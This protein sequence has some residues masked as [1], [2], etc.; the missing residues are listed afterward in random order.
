MFFSNHA[1]IQKWS[2]VC[3]L[4]YHMKITEPIVLIL[5]IYIVNISEYNRHTHFNFLLFFKMVS[6]I[7]TSLQSLLNGSTLFN[8]VYIYYIKQTVHLSKYLMTNSRKLIKLS[9]PIKCLFIYLSISSHC[10][11]EVTC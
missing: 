7:I 11:V 2:C 5:C 9:K 6:L 8:L 1:N 4:V 10:P 3:F